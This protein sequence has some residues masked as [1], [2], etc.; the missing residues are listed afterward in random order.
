VFFVVTVCGV[1]IPEGQ[2]GVKLFLIYFERNFL[3]TKAQRRNGGRQKI[4]KRK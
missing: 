1:N 4:K 2:G 3:T